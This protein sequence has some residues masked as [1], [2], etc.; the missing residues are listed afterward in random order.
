MVLD[1]DIYVQNAE[2]PKWHIPK[3]KPRA[4]Q[5][6]LW[7]LVYDNDFYPQMPHRSVPP[8]F[9]QPWRT[10]GS[11]WDTSKGR[12]FTFDNATGTGSLHFDRNANST[13]H[14]V[15]DFLVYDAGAGLGMF[16]RPGAVGSPDDDNANPVSDLKLSAYYTR[17]SGDGPFRLI[18]SR[19]TDV[20]HTF[21]AEIAR[22]GIHLIHRTSSGEISTMDKTF[23]EAG[24]N[25]DKPM[26]VELSNV[27]YRVTLR[28]NGNDVFA[29]P[30]DYE[31]NVDWLLDQYHNHPRNRKFPDARIEAENQKCT[32]AHISLYRDVYYTNRGNALHT[33]TPDN[34]VVLNPGE[35]F[36][37]GDNSAISKDARYWDSPID[38]PHEGL[39]MAEGRVPEQFMLGKAVFVYWPAGYRIGGVPYSI[40]PNF[41][42]M[43]WIH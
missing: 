25:P 26:Y 24:I 6:A 22:D 37:M 7:R 12:T 1:G 23:A 18:V 10:D 14:T 11:G 5:D 17:I 8:E 30:M 33:G 43:R 20:D 36:V 9:V 34:P 29:K 21:S 32:L 31:P 19:S 27:D 40:I 35:Y 39:D 2:N 41:G 38:L 16:R 42:D 28:I 13:T 4:A 3:D 15:T